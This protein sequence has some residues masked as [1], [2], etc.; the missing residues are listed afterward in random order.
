MGASE[1]GSFENEGGGAVWAL[2][3]AKD[4]ARFCQLPRSSSGI[5]CSIFKGAAPLG[6]RVRGASPATAALL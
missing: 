6:T 1:S 5:A 4:A 3:C 2:F